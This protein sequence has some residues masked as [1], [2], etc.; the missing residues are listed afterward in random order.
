MQEEP[1]SNFALISSRSFTDR[2]PS[3]ATVEL[4]LGPIRFVL[5]E[6]TIREYIA[7]AT[8]SSD[9]FINEIYGLCL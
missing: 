3:F 5:P 4:F 8:A 1:T 2:I 7:C 9:S 6:F